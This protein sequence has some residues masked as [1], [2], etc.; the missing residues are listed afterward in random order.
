MSISQ[1]V[2]LSIGQFMDSQVQIIFQLILAFFLIG[3]REFIE[4]IGFT[5]AIALGMGGIIIVFL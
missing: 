1:L 2:I 3:V 5:G 4:V